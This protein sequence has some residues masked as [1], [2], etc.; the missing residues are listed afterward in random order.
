MGVVRLSEVALAVV[1][2]TAEPEELLSV[3]QGSV[4]FCEAPETPGVMT[5]KT[6]EGPL[7]PVFSSLAELATARGAV[8][9]FSTTGLDLLDLLP[10]GH[11]LLLDPAG[12]VPL[13]LR[14][15]SLRRVVHVS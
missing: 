7:V 5:V 10:A 11:D 6:P 4:V 3:L 14:T 2:G 12:P 8:A 13:R 9:W 15:A 1:A